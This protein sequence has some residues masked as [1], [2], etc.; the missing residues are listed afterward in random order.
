MLFF[1]LLCEAI[2]TAAAPVIL[3]QPLVIMK[4]IM[5]KHGMFDWQGKLK[6]SEKTCPSVTFAHHKIPQDQTRVST[7]AAA[8][9]CR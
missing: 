4:M 5:E 1:Y 3:C 9:G 7:P 2:G 6:F 8:V